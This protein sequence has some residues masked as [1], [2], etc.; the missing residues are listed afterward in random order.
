MGTPE[1]RDSKHPGDGHLPFPASEFLAL[2]T[3]AAQAR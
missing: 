2:V 1:V 3:A